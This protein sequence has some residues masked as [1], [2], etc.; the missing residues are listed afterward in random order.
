MSGLIL[1]VED[2][3]DL[4]DNLA[5][6]LAREG[7]QTRL[8]Q[9]GRQALELAAKDPPPDLV[10]LDVMLPDLDGFEVCRQLRRDA[11]TRR[12][13]V[14]MLTARSEEVDRVVGFEVGADDYVVKPFSPREL[15]LRVRA[16]LRRG[17]VE[18]DG[19]PSETLF[20]LLRVDPAAHRVW[21]QAREIVL[22]ALEFRL[23]AT[24]LA[25]KGRVQSREMLLDTVWGI[26]A[27]VT[28]RTVDTHVKRLREK[29]GP[30]GAYVE[31]LRGVG[32]RF[33]AKPDQEPT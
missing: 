14:L 11:R 1:V 23:L 5:Y 22:T 12:T 16:L 2:E 6:N 18:E 28:T 7:Y 27:E 20:G 19:A 26:Q 21:V 31:T 8:A 33:K 4:L 24:L 30:A 17:R 32:Y 29:L 13:L 25:R 15:L 3:K 10:L 9:N